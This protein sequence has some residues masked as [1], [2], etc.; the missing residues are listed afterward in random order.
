MS[1]KKTVESS[2][3]TNQKTTQTAASKIKSIKSGP[4]ITEV[5]ADEEEFYDDETENLKT[6]VLEAEA[7]TAKTEKSEA[8]KTEKA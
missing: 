2:Q 6:D 7:K 5:L 1:K 8:S 3:K 4:D